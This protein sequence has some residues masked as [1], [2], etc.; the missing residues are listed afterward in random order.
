M[1]FEF[2]TFPQGITIDKTAPIMP[3]RSAADRRR[4]GIDPAWLAEMVARRR[5]IYQPWVDRDV[6]TFDLPPR[7]TASTLRTLRDQIDNISAYEVG[8]CENAD[9]PPA[10]L[11][12]YSDYSFDWQT[13]VRA[14][15]PVK[16]VHTAELFDALRTRGKYVGCA[17]EQTGDPLIFAATRHR[18]EHWSDGGAPTY[19]DEPVTSD[20]EI[21]FHQ[22]NAYAYKDSDD[23]VHSSTDE[24]TWNNVHVQTS[25][26][27]PLGTVIKSAWIASLVRV[28]SFGVYMTH[29]KRNNATGAVILDERVDKVLYTSVPVTISGGEF[30]VPFAD[31][32]SL[33]PSVMAAAGAADVSLP[34]PSVDIIDDFSLTVSAGEY[35]NMI[36][37]VA[38][39]M[40]P[41]T[42]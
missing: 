3:R 33:V 39:D 12:A 5:A 22:W 6:L 15:R 42:D 37:T 19:P 25:P 23:T 1:D 27:Y 38:D 26:T 7:P 30:I 29:T 40:I 24:T 21:F 31:F 16:R 34:V 9:S 10:Y 20:R 14:G 13:E 36:A 4:Y 32:I 18:E 35:G 41:P 11:P 28:V 8:S 17:P 2:V